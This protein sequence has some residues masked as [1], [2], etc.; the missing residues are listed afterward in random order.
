M[1][2]K[3]LRE[4]GV[5]ELRQKERELREEVCRLRLRKGVSQLENPMKMRE[6]RRELARI[7]T[8]L[9]ESQRKGNQG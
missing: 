8:V 2:A 1:L 6:S 9:R 4:L 3:E 7:L 5:E